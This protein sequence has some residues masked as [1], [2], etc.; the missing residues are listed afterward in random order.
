MSVQVS[1]SNRLA[2]DIRVEGKISGKQAEITWQ[3]ATTRGSYRLLA[4]IITRIKSNNY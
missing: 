1:A 3:R 2:A 4:R